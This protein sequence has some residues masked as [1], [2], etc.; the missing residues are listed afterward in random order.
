MCKILAVVK[1]ISLILV[2]VGVDLEFIP[3]ILDRR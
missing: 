2:G 1:K 3:G